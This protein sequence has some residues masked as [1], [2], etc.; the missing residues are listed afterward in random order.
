MPAQN[1]I[2]PSESLESFIAGMIRDARKRLGWRQ[3]D[4]AAKVFS[5][6]TRISEIENGD[7]PDLK[8]GRQLDQVLELGGAMANLLVI[9]DR[10]AFRDYAQ[11]FLRDQARARTIHE[12]SLSV[13]G[14]LQT[15][16]YARATMQ[17]ADPSGE[18]DLDAAV[19]RRAE[20]QRVFEG[21]RPPWFWVVL[22]EN[23]LSKV[24]GSKQVMR[25][26]IERLLEAVTCP[27]INIQ[28]LEATRS[29]IAGSVSLL[30]LPSG[31]RT[32]Y[33]EGFSTG[34][35]MVEAADVDRFQ[36]I[37]D[38]LHAD[39]LGTVESEE[40]IREALGKHDD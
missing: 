5:S 35:Y 26:Q 18:G 1:D 40:I 29:S 34:R 27:F 7:P 36:R 33:T 23:A 31:E 38:R 24:I 11:G 9:R 10:T 32:A 3:Q 13:P 22:D 39:A 14:L 21:E 16:E 28:I 37:Y 2:D 17:L 19:R 30:T 12:F 6:T 15:P 4:L 25:G 8:L 20:R